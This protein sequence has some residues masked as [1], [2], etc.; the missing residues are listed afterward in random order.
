MNKEFIYQVDNKDYLVVVTYKRIRN[1][2]YAKMYKVHAE[3]MKNN[4]I[5]MPSGDVKEI[6]KKYFFVE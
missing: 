1:I 5:T 6:E 3:G 2:H 4:L